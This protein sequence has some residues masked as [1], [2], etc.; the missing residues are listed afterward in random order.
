MDGWMDVRGRRAFTT[1]DCKPV[2]SHALALRKLFHRRGEFVESL[3]WMDGWMDVR[4]GVHSP[5]LGFNL[6]CS[7]AL[8]LGK[9]FCR[10][11][12]I[13]LADNNL[14]DEGVEALSVGLKESKSLKALD[15]LNAMRAST[16]FGPKGATALASAISVMSSVTELNLFNNTIKDQGVTAICEAVQS[17]KETKLASLNVGYNGIGPAGAKS[18]AAM[19]AAI[20]SLT[21]IS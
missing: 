17:N 7:H 1:V 10:Q 12:E 20:A 4:G 11:E 15:V 9:I 21:K 5:P 19:A 8:S 3:G 13:F 14:G 18:V 2:G 6:F 16:K